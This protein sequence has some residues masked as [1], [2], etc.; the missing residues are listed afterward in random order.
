MNLPK[1]VFEFFSPPRWWDRAWR[2]F[3]FL[4]GR[5]PTNNADGER[6]LRPQRK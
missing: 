4:R 6:K 5:H 1:E 3:V 2:V